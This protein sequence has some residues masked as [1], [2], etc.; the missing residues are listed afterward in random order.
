MNQPRVAA[1]VRYESAHEPDNGAFLEG[2][3]T[4]LAALLLA[5]V[6]AFAVYV[7][8]LNSSLSALI[9]VPFGQVGRFVAGH[10]RGMNGGAQTFQYLPEVTLGI[11]AVIG[12][13]S[14]RPVIMTGGI[15]A[16]IL[17]ALI[18]PVMVNFL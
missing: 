14:N 4:T 8:S 3:V 17:S 12:A 6:F 11:L 15:V 5:I 2:V 7:V 16:A 18:R 13:V 9:E 10:L 1:S